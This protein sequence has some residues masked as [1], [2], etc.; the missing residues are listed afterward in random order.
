M[1]LNSVEEVKE[2]LTTIKCG[3]PIF[4]INVGYGDSV[5]LMLEDWVE[6]K[7]LKKSGDAI[8]EYIG[9]SIERS[10]DNESK[11]LKIDVERVHSKMSDYIYNTV[12][13]MARE[14][15]TSDQPKRTFAYKEMVEIAYQNKREEVFQNDI[16]P[17]LNYYYKVKTESTNKSDM[18]V[19][20]N[21][22]QALFKVITKK[23]GNKKKV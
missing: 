13:D 16:L 15:S 17:I 9:H 1:S 19:H 11:S 18:V 20:N 8:L 10:Y 12:V 14:T 21:N 22:V 23:Y 7:A 2:F 6:K 5:S 3:E 4:T